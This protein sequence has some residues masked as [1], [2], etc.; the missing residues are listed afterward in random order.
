MEGGLP[1]FGFFL[2]LILFVI[3]IYFRLRQR[4][5]DRQPHG[6]QLWRSGAKR[7]RM[8]RIDGAK[9]WNDRRR[10]LETQEPELRIADRYLSPEARERRRRE[11]AA[12]ATSQRAAGGAA[13]RDSTEGER[14]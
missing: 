4:G 2:L 14:S 5:R 12:R 11:E 13:P 10:R 9:S 3:W 8:L 1:P 7:R 6:R